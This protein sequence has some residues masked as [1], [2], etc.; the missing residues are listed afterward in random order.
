VDEAQPWTIAQAL[1]ARSLE[2]DDYVDS[3]SQNWRL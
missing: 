2:R 1:A 3:P